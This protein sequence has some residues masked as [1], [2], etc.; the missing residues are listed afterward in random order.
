[1][2]EIIEI[3]IQDKIDPK[4]VIDLK[5][6]GEA[7]EK[8]HGKITA[9][10]AALQDLNKLSFSAIKSDLNGIKDAVSKDVVQ[11]K[12]LNDVMSASK[13]VNDRLSDSVNKIDVAV[14][15]NIRSFTGLTEAQLK[16]AMATT[17]LE[18]AQLRY[19]LATNRQQIAQLKLVSVTDQEAFAKAQLAI[20]TKQ[21]ESA[22]LKEIV[23]TRQL[24]SALIRN[25]MA[26]VRA[27]NAQAKQAAQAAKTAA[28]Q[29]QLNA[30]VKSAN[31]DLH[32]YIRTMIAFVATARS[33]SSGFGLLNTYSELQNKLRVVADSQERVNYLTERVADIA[34]R[35]RTPVEETA[36]AFQRFDLAM[37]NLGA[38]QEE[39]LR[40]TETVNKAMT[41]GGAKAGEQA[42]GLL[43]LSQAF[44]KGKLDGDEFRTVMEL[45]PTLVDAIAAEFTR[46][47]GGITVTRGDLLKMAPEGKIT[48]EI[49]RKAF[50]NA[51]EG[52]DKSFSKMAM[53][54]AQAMTLLRNKMVL[55]FGK[56]ESKHHLVDKFT[57]SITWMSEHIDELSVGIASLSS[58]VA[59]AFGPKIIAGINGFMAALAKNPWG[60]AIVGITTLVSYLVM[61]ED[62]IYMSE[63]SMVTFGDVVR[64]TFNTIKPYIESTV[65]F[66][67]EAWNSAINSATGDTS[68]FQRAVGI[69][70]KGVTTYLKFAVNYWLN[71]F[72]GFY[73]FVTEGVS[74]LPRVFINIFNIIKNGLI[75][76]VSDAVDSL[77][78]MIS[79]FNEFNDYT[80]NLILDEGFSLINVDNLKKSKVEIDDTLGKFSDTMKKAFTW[81]DHAGA[82]FE[83][84]KANIE[85][86][87]LK[88]LYEDNLYGPPLPEKKKKGS[89][90]IKFPDKKDELSDLEKYDELLN[91]IIKDME[92]QV[93]SYRTLG[94]EHAVYNKMIEIENKFISKKLQLREEDRA[95]FNSVLR[96]IE[97]LSATYNELNTIYENNA[98]YI[99]NVNDKQRAYNLALKRGII[100]LHGYNKAMVELNDEVVKHGFND[101]VLSD[102]YDSNTVAIRELRNEIDSYQ[103]ALE[104]GIVNSSQFSR[105]LAELENR[106]IKIAIEKSDSFD[107]V[108]LNVV[109]DFKGL[110]L[111]L[112]GIFTNLFDNF[113]D[114]FSNAIGQAIV[115]GEDL[116]STLKS[117]M[118]SAISAVIAE[119]IRMTIKIAIAK[120]MLNVVTSGIG[121]A[122]SGA[123]S[124]GVSAG[125][126]A[127]TASVGSV[128]AAAFASGGYT[129]NYPINAPV[130]IVHGR[131][132]VFDAEST[133]RIGV[134][135]LKALQR[136]SLKSTE[137]E[138]GSVVKSTGEDKQPINVKIINSL[139][140]KIVGDFL[141][142]SEG[143]EVILN[144]IAENSETAR[145]ILS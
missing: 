74:L 43:Q 75:D 138:N 31:N 67:K 10:Q 94:K 121:G 26:T 132:Y 106:K 28:K 144:A 79:A 15:K 120:T 44:N 136:G 128:G 46:M 35:T 113:I 14:N 4:I 134:D 36:R 56:L 71:L 114:G 76:F 11:V 131:E 9:L 66:F 137:S 140:P 133:R 123:A 92:T 45:M 95:E 2:G 119:V 69:V 6:I 59:V 5:A 96:D 12:A 142:T 139:D 27:A 70:M 116:A 47:R 87:N 33:L 88:R 91:S 143:Q 98:G 104:K 89:R 19:T 93:V 21:A 108:L 61:F 82:F 17:Q 63:K 57:S 130:G 145:S 125:Q 107:R 99:E 22:A 65:N 112:E 118:K 38:S 109:S 34:N 41:V 77:N 54:P 124:A 52:I 111:E 64:G 42:A 49:L 58:I 97:D 105:Q 73:I 83:K 90:K 18:M 81:D 141:S 20:Q 122:A 40:L 117:V 110:T 48:A 101:E 32:L 135:N 55:F 3:Q 23:A 50:A 16:D 85:E 78:S 102:L 127:A 100:D 25:E 39:S 80:G 37:A 30:V 68:F 1:M 13:V 29:A 84:V 7:A 53:T 62:Q 126:S 115:N 103:I 129:G 24:E 51:T 86:V 60:L 72:E 8:S